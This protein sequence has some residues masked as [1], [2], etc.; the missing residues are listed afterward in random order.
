MLPFKSN[1]KTERFTDIVI[2]LIKVIN[3]T[4]L[5]RCSRARCEFGGSP[6]H[7]RNRFSIADRCLNKE[8]T[9]GVPRGTRGAL[10][11]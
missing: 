7:A 11:K 1:C 8:L 9:T 2:Y 5:T 6:T 4:L 10:H 3:Q